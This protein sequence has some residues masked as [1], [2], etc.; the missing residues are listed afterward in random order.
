MS[1]GT[2]TRRKL[3]Q[4][5]AL[6]GCSAAAHPL[7]TSVVFADAPW[8]NRLVV[9]ILRGAMDGMEAVRPMGDP[10]FAAMRPNLMSRSKPGHDLDGFFSLHPGLGDLMPLWRAGELGFIHAVSTPYRDKRSHFDGQDMLETGTALDL[11]SPVQRDG[12]LNRLLQVVPGV[13]GRTAF[14]VGRENPVILSGA[15]QT[16]SWSPEAL[17][18]LPQRTQRLLQEIYHDDPLFLGATEQALA[19]SEEIL[20]S[21]ALS[22][23]M[24]PSPDMAAGAGGSELALASF[25]A[26]QLRQ[27]TRIATFSV[28]GWDTHRSQPF[29]VNGRLSRLAQVILQLKQDLGP[30]WGKTTVMAMTEFGRTARENGT[31]GTDHGTGGLMILAGGGVRGGKV[32]GRWPGLGEADLYARRDLMPTGDVRAQAAWG[33]RGLF[34]LDRATLETQ[35]F[36]GLQLGDKPGFLL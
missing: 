4:A 3:M 21:D 19:L 28:N 29:Q 17:L 20:A 34:G 33:M 16:S 7:M 25:A 6:L 26:K 22:N 8:E 13:S 32:Y 15:A 31:M 30:V 27:D 9:L 35:V 23:G 10:R 36:P 11:A 14:A 24:A 18:Q 12:W 1:R 2:V 5:S